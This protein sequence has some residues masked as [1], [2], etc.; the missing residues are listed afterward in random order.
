MGAE[1]ERERGGHH[2][3]GDS[4]ETP[5]VSS[6]MGVDNGVPSVRLRCAGMCSFCSSDLREWKPWRPASECKVAECQLMR[7]HLKQQT[8]EQSRIINAMR[9]ARDHRLSDDIVPFKA[10]VERL[11]ATTDAAIRSRKQAEILAASRLKI[12]RALETASINQTQKIASLTEEIASLNMLV[13]E[14][15][16]EARLIHELAVV[17][18]KRHLR[19]ERQW[20]NPKRQVADLE[21]RL[22]KQ[23]Q[24]ARADAELAR[25]NAVAAREEAAEEARLAA[26]AMKASY[27]YEMR[28]L[29]RRLERV[30]A[31]A[32]KI[33]DEEY[34]PMERSA[35]EWA[36]LNAEAQRKAAQRECLVL[37]SFFES[38]AWRPERASQI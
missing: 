29:E 7:A 14:R 13:E 36:A 20:A 3:V 6:P 25:A 33:R 26:E 12:S 37:R 22:E 10:E 27:A 23:L 31:R 38:H 30:E 15:A 8:A 1:E 17:E 34:R 16:R 35:E 9:A 4:L 11:R 19:A 21:A 18:E 5:D 32:V 28:L 2:G 24:S